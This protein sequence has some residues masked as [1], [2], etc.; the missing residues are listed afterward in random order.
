MLSGLTLVIALVVVCL[1]AAVMGTVSFGMGLVVT[2]VLLLFLEAREAVVIAN[3]LIG[4]LLCVVVFQTR[5]QLDLRRVGGMTLGGL[6]AVPLGVLALDR[7]NSAALR[8]TI[9]LVILALCLLTLLNVRLPLAQRRFAGPV[10]GFLSSLSVTTTS[11]GGPL[12][13]FYV[14]AQGWPTPVM[15]A[16]LAFYFLVADAASFGFYLWAGLVTRDTITNIGLLLP[17]LLLGLAASALLLRRMNEAVFRYAAI[18][19]SAAGSLMLLVREL[20]RL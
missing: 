2:P 16:S 3:T 13:A 9:A 10:F 18:A 1:G 17:A 11:I 19:V 6:A 20:T 4:L 8:V 12:A 15:R 14:M 5:R 7:A